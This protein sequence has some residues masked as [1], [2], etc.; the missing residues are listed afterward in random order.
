MHSLVVSHLFWPRFKKNSLKL[1][2]QLGKLAK[3]YE[4]SFTKLKPEKRLEWLP[5]LGSVTLEVQLK[6][7]TLEIDATPLQA[8]V[9]EMFD[10]KGRYLPR[11]R[12]RPP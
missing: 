9:L 6:D 3:Q 8:A 10:K 11:R 1:P 7:R 12:Y 4:A 5:T 2:G